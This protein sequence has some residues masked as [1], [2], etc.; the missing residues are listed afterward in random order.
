MPQEKL[1]ILTDAE[2]LEA[3]KTGDSIA[4]DALYERYWLL[5]YQAAFRRL[6]D[7]SAAEDI[8]QDIFLQLWLRRQ[9][10]QIDY[11]KSYLLTSVR[12][13]VLK[14]MEKENRI[15]PVDKLL[16]EI[17]IHKGAADAAIVEKELKRLYETVISGLPRAQ[18]QIF[19]MRF[20]QDLSTAEIAEQLQ[21]SR[22]TVQNQ[23]G[24]SVQHLKESLLFL[25][26]LFFLK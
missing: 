18:Q 16:E 2:L 17:T 12:N 4:F 1:T 13:N 24:K 26:V 8:T 3:L 20:E 21:L 23:L 7:E 19:R 15:V 11:L 22:K 25:A 9:E 14:R 6:R 10:L 5:V